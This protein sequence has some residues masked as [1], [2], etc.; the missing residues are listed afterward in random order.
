M[1]R[2]SVWIG[3]WLFFVIA[4]AL[5]MTMVLVTLPQL[6]VGPDNLRPFDARPFGY[7]PEAARAYLAGLSEAA[8]ATYLGLQHRLDA[9]FPAANALWMG[10]AV[11]L[12]F[13]GRVRFGLIAAIGVFT[14]C[15]Y[16]EN[17]AVSGMLS[18]GPAGPG[19]DEITRASLFTL[20]KSMGTTIVWISLIF[21]GVTNWLRRRRG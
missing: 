21:G 12:A 14:L 16:L 20:G 17:A 2:R 9:F 3:F 15:D 13:A 1:E 5:Y 4:G 6:L 11:V 8:R 10:C 19:D 18:A 7:T